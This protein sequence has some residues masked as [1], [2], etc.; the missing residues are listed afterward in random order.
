[1]FRVNNENAPALAEIC[2]QLDGIP[3][4]IELAAARTKAMSV[5]QIQK[6]LGKRFTLLTG[7]K[8]TALPRQQTLKSLIDWSYDLLS[9][10]EKMLWNR[11]SVFSGGWKLEAAEKICSGDPIAEDEIIELLSGLTEKSI[12]LYDEI[13]ERFRMLETI[14]QY[15]DEKLIERNEFEVIRS[16][17][18]GY[19]IDLAGFIE[20]KLKDRKNDIS[21][22]MRYMD[23][24]RSNLEK[25]LLICVEGSKHED[26]MTLAFRMSAYWEIK[27]QIHEGLR[28]L[29]TAVAGY[30]DSRTDLQYNVKAQIANLNRL[31]GNY[32]KAKLLF[33]ECLAISKS[34]GDQ[35]EAAHSLNRLGMIA[36]DE[37]DFG[38]A[39]DYYTESLAVYEKC[40]DKTSHARVLNNLGNVRSNQARYSEAAEMYERSLAVRRET[41]DILGS[42]ITMN[43]LGILAYERGDYQKAEEMLTESLRIRA[44]V[45]DK[46]GIGICNDNLGNLAYNRGNY[47]KAEEYYN[48]SYEIALETA[49]EAGLAEALHNKGKNSLELT[50][51]SEAGEF[52]GKS[53]EIARKLNS[54]S[55]MASQL[56]LAGRISFVNGDHTESRRQYE[57]SVSLFLK[58]GNMKDVSLTLIRIAELSSATGDP[59][60][61]AVLLGF[62]ECEFAE[63]KQVI[64]PGT[65]R[66]AIDKTTEFAKQQLGQD[67][68][69]RQYDSG[70]NMLLNEV[71][72]LVLTDAK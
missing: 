36:Y 12:I 54:G 48:A 52:L 22:W 40:N 70:R 68:F 28:W 26:L 42:A 33:G 5:E 2:S 56:C 38:A 53:M 1:N 15:G 6:R 45:G 34:R 60:L 39:S 20:K 44:E 72:G 49:N 71:V 62:I 4:A 43:N 64:F 31:A 37:G 32:E 29:E 69:E 21:E 11:L 3:L 61:S 65:D 59:G 14:R 13:T 16:K 25:S 55:L 9:E 47:L 18:I 67:E 35:K 24:E 10:D 30:P 50:N 23:L 57:E 58:T 46:A 17:F 8:R 7:G 66:A 27:G 19:Y 63:K 41:G 51:S